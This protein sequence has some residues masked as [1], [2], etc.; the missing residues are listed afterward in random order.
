MHVD[1]LEQSLIGKDPSG[2]T[3]DRIVET[4]GFVGVLDGSAGPLGQGRDGITTM[5]DRAVQLLHKMP[6][7][8]DLPQMVEV[9]S[10][11]VRAVKADIGLANLRQTG[12]YV[13]CLLARDV[14]EIWRVGDCKFRDGSAPVDRCFAAEAITARMRAMMIEARLAEGL[15]VAEIMAQPDYGD[16]VAPQ[17]LEQS[18]LLNREDHP[19]SL[20]AI[21]GT[22]VP[23]GFLDRYPA[24]A[25]RLA[26]ASDGYPEVFES[27]AESEAYLNALLTAD[28]LCIGVNMQ[29]KGLAPDLL[30]FDDR[31]FVSVQ[32][33]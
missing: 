28:P 14:G 33:R 24:R 32:L 30:S 3:E 22:A 18:R 26:L 10:A 12:G 6:V 11:D 8:T 29:C 5:L 9:L 1:I 4:R 23:P 21:N 2:Y 7:G 19:L 13:F 27:L 25:G 31:A 20:G 17:L 16:L 15:S